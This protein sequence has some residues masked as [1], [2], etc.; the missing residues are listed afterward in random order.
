ML[1][2]FEGNQMV[3]K[4][5]FRKDGYFKGMETEVCAAVDGWMHRN[6]HYK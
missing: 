1:F 3:F 4:H 5:L 2:W 6:G